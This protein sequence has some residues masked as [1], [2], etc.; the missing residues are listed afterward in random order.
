MA[1]GSLQK[2]RLLFVGLPVTP[3]F[4]QQFFGVCGLSREKVFLIVGR[5]AGG[6]LRCADSLCSAVLHRVGRTIL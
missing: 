1:A 4:Q 3:P 5:Q 2:A 6:R